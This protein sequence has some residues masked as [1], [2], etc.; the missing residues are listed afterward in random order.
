[1]IKFTIIL[2]RNANLTHEQFVDHHKNKHAALFSSLAEVKQHVRR[3]VQV[4]S[5]GDALAGMPDSRIDGLTEIWFDDLAG[6][7][8]VF[9]SDNYMKKIR[10]DEEA[11]LDLPGC[12]FI[13]GTEST[14]IKQ[15]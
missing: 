8:G 2:R 11:F 9:Q 10:P 14:V 6:L 4:H 7:A 1:M 5:T 15:G 12:E 3:Y 13:V